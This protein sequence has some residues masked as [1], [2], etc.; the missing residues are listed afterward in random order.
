MSLFLSTVT[1]KIDKKGRVSV[2]ARFRS[3]L[4]L[5][6]FET[7]ILFPSIDGD[8]LNA[9]DMGVME[10]LLQKIGGFDPMSAERDDEADVLMAEA[11]ELPIDGDGRI[12]IPLHMV[13]EAGFEGE[14]VFVGRGDSFQI[15]HPEA[16]KARMQK[17]KAKA[18]E[19]RERGGS[20]GRGDT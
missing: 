13:E 20:I 11:I 7:V 19:K 18:R 15:W 17:A 4:A 2:P 16:F 8:C 6:G 10:G 14:C 9:C 5:R 1:N 3:N 12:M